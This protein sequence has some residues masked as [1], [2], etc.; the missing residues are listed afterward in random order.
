MRSFW[1][2]EN[3]LSEMFYNKSSFKMK[4]FYIC[5]IMSQNTEKYF[6]SNNLII[7]LDLTHSLCR[8]SGVCGLGFGRNIFDSR[9][10]EWCEPYVYYNNHSFQDF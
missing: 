7:S 9:C 6:I 10:S 1:Y 8:N 2:G 3:F 4:L 5:V